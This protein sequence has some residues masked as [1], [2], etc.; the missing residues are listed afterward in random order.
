MVNWSR[1]QARRA[2]LLASTILRRIRPRCSLSVVLLLSSLL[3]SGCTSTSV[4]PSQPPMVAQVL[5]FDEPLAS[6]APDDIRTAVEGSTRSVLDG[7][8]AGIREHQVCRV[9]TSTDAWGRSEYYCP[10]LSEIETEIF[11]ELMALGLL[12]STYGEFFS[13]VWTGKFGPLL[14]SVERCFPECTWPWS[15]TT[16]ESDLQAFTA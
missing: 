12:L 6:S 11:K 7:L 1:Q 16:N 9:S 2:T 8:R 5:Q 3:V 13:P 10:R 4:T 15:M 14:K